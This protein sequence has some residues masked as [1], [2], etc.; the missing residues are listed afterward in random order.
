[1]QSLMINLLAVTP[2]ILAGISVFYLVKKYGVYL[3][4]I[5]SVPLRIL[6]IVV[7]TLTA[8]ILWA[9]MSHTL[10]KILVWF[11]ELVLPSRAETV[12]G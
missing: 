9:L 1:M 12:I 10:G 5:H 8:L 7:A 6:G 11:L 3:K 2:A 4:K